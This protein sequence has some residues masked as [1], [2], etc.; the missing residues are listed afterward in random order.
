MLYVTTRSNSETYTAYHALTENRAPDGGFYVP[1]RLPRFDRDQIESLSKRPF[2]QTVAEIL[3]LLFG[4]K[5]TAFDLD[6]S[7][8][9]SPVRL[10]ALGHR[11]LLGECWHNLSWDY[12]QMERAIYR[13]VVEEED[14]AVSDWFR[15]GLRIAVLFGFFGKLLRRQIAS[16]KAPVDLAVLSGDFSAPMAA[17]YARSMG[18]P[19]GNII[20]CC[21]D[22]NNP[23]ELL[24]HG[25]IRTNTV[26]LS[27]ITPAG[28][29]AIPTDLERFVHG[30]GGSREVERFVELCRAGRMYIPTDH[31][32]EQMQQGM[33]ASVVGQTRVFSAIPNVY[34]THG[35]VLDPYA[36]LIYSGLLDYRAGT[37]ES[38]PALILSDIGPGAAPGPIAD[39]MGISPEELQ[40][41]LNNT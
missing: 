29:Y 37:G 17:W 18:L 5:L 26:A 34:R 4:C 9:R 22:N 30:C 11:I 41:I 12:G 2:N 31:V 7:I 20:L 23:W 27:T 33:Y 40:E 38:K 32:Y 21:N 6:F 16:V 24:H 15:I 19:I 3:N 36:A 14:K 39:A 13:K 8:G 28:D 10:T 35:E 25:E 1:L